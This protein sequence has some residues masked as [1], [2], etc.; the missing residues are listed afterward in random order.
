MINS[1][2][3]I[4][5]VFNES[6]RLKLSLLKIKN[7]LKLYKK[8]FYDLEVIFVDDGSLDNTNKILSKF[9][10]SSFEKYNNVSFKI[11]KLDK[12]YGKGYALK[13]GV[14]LAKK[15]WVLTLDIDL[16]VELYEL[17]VWNDLYIS[18]K[19]HIYFASR[20]LK[21]SK[22]KKNFFRN[23]LGHIFRFLINK[24]FNISDLD[25]QCGFKLY[26]KEKAKKIFSMIHS[27]RFVHDI[28]IVIICKKLGLKICQLPVKWIHKPYGKINIFYHPFVMFLDLIKIYFKIK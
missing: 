21:K 17:I 26:K 4:F 23:F 9:I 10:N 27:K 3:I 2:S 11:I 1:L 8:N 25:S 16:S 28:E 14:R 12:N 15:K 20:L 22:V 19:F 6:S 7:F 13:R 24:L 5:P 18:E